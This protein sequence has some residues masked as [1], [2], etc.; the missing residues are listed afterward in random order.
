MRA[1]AGLLAC[2]FIVLVSCERRQPPRETAGVSHSRGRRVPQPY[3]SRMLDSDEIR[4]LIEE[5]MPRCL[6][7]TDPKRLQEQSTCLPLEM[8]KDERNGLPVILVYTCN[9]LCP[10]YG[11]SLSSIRASKLMMPS[12]VPPADIRGGPPGTSRSVPFACPKSSH[13]FTGLSSTLIAGGC[14]SKRPSAD[15]ASEPSSRTAR[16]HDPRV[17]V[18]GCD[19][20]RACDLLDT[21]YRDA[22]VGTMGSIRAAAAGSV[23][24]VSST[25]RPW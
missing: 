7:T 8:G 17:P 2:F 10:A 12:A 3:S 18:L 16:A 23:P 19:L 24:S 15:P 20:P 9:D 25:K 21:T 22:W 4:L 1:R 14:G 13:R 5:G 6:A 11:G